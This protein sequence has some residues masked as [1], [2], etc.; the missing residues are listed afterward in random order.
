[1]RRY[2]WVVA[3]GAALVACRK[4]PQKAAEYEMVLAE[5]RDISVTVSAAGTIQ[6]VLTVEVKSK[7]SGEITA[8]HVQSGAEV[9]AGQLL[10]EVDPRIPRNN[11]DQTFANVNVARAQLDNARMQLARSDTLYKAQAITETEYESA[12]L[13]YAAAVAGEVRARTD[14]QGSRDALEDTKLR[15]PMSGTIIDKHVELGTV[16][17]SPTRDVGGGT[18]IFTMAN[19]DTVQLQAMVDE[20]DIGKVRE[21]LPVTITVDAYPHRPF[22]GTVLKIEPKAQVQQNVTMFP[23]LVNIA[24]AGH[25]LKPGMNAE[26][27]VRVGAR[28]NVLAIPNAALRTEDDISAVANWLG[29]DRKVLRRRLERSAA[30][31]TQGGSASMGTGTQATDPT[32]PSGAS[33]ATSA[34]ARPASAVDEP[35]SQGSLPTA[36][37]ADSRHIA[38]V[39]R[40]GKPTPLHVTTGLTDLDYTE[41]LRGV[42]EGDTVLVLPTASLV[43]Q[44][45]R[46]QRKAQQRGGGLPGISQQ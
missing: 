21:G 37:V 33:P 8:M 15:A 44:L 2:L 35:A 3:I 45:E 16:I 34:P 43:K 5:R 27:E 11:M 9:R 38:F 6:P 7:A 1:M 28:H 18:I 14:L 24:N 13:A 29:A 36:E 4:P 42:S 31:P 20:T 22:P 12:R 26:I 30:V 32:R 25:L 40:G 41:V 46:Q 17:S 23:V 19:L 10:A 39:L